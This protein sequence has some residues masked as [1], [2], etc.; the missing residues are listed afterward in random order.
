ML[1]FHDMGDWAEGSVSATF[2]ACTQRIAPGAAEVIERSWE[3]AMARLGEKLFDGPMCRLEAVSASPEHLALSLS[4]TSY[5]LFLGTNLD[6]PHLAERFGERV[7]ANPMGVSCA[8]LSADG[9]LMMGRR[10]DSVAYYPNR[11]HPF[12]GALEPPAMAAQ[13]GTLNVFDEVRRELREELALR[14]AD[15]AGIRCMGVAEDMAIHQ[16]ELIFRVNAARTRAEIEA[17]LDA[18][19]HEATWSIPATAEAIERALAETADLTPIGRA[20]LLLYGRSAFGAAW[21]EARRA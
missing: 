1:R 16:P 20:A 15:L 21:F 8:L 3:R 12:A 9:F 10:N 4:R 7:L 19:E 5:K 17:R 14:P 18:A 13:P 2:T 6:N 11:L